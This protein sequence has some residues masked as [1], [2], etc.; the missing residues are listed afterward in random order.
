MTQQPPD[1][2]IH[3]QTRRYSLVDP[4]TGGLLRP[5]PYQRQGRPVVPLGSRKESRLRDGDNRFAYAGLTHAGGA[6]KRKY[7]GHPRSSLH[8][9]SIRL[10]SEPEIDQWYARIA[11]IQQRSEES[12]PIGPLLEK[13]R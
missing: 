3:P 1:L 4:G 11:A 6:A 9:G 13:T 7:A 2:V 10:L 8:G 5:G 12:K